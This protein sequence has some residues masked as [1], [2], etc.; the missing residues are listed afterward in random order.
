MSLN[1]TFLLLWKNV[2][3]RI[4]SINS[5]GKKL[6]HLLIQLASYLTANDNYVQWH[7]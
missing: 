6:A 3:L 1:V 5:N 4:L 2:L 7:C